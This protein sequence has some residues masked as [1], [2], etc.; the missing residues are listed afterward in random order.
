M[1]IIELF[2]ISKVNAA[3]IK[4]ILEAQ[5]K[6]QISYIT[7]INILQDIRKVIADYMKHKYRL[8]KIGC[9][10]D[11]NKIIAI[12]ETLI[13]HDQGVQRWLVGVLK[14]DQKK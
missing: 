3:Q 8:Y 9:D 7:I 4:N 1:H 13:I 6:I 12:D 5:K 11:T 2:I 14:L 10:P